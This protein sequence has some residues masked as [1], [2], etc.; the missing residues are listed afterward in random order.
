MSAKKL[1]AKCMA[2]NPSSDR[3]ITAN[4]ALDMLHEINKDTHG[5]IYKVRRAISIL[6]RYVHTETKKKQLIFNR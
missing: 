3:L 2:V 5:R 1:I 6:S 4:R